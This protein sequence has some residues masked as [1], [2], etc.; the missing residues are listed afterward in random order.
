MFYILLILLII[1]MI[2]RNHVRRTRI[3]HK[4]IILLLEK[5]GE[6]S[7]FELQHLT[8]LRG[9]KFYF[10]MMQMTDEGIVFKD[11]NLYKLME[12]V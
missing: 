10:L 2:I 5:Y 11:E 3:E 12:S 9:V 1:Y 7:A 4:L 6:L 8:T